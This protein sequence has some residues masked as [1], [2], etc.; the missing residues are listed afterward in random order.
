MTAQR[1]REENKKINQNEDPKERESKQ[2]ETS[3]C[4]QI[5]VLS[6]E[7]KL[8]AKLA[9]VLPTLIDIVFT[10]LVLCCIQM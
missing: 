10:Y 3:K 8:N 9:S 2:K 4:G 7:K 1:L 6:Q 5:Y